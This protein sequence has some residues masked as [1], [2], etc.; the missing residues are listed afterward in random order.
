M[1]NNGPRTCPAPTVHLTIRISEQALELLARLPRQF[2]IYPVALARLAATPQGVATGE[3]HDEAVGREHEVVHERQEHATVDVAE[4]GSEAHPRVVKGTRSRRQQQADERER[5]AETTEDDENVRTPAVEIPRGDEH[6][7]A[8]DNERRLARLRVGRARA[9]RVR[10]AAA[11]LN[12]VEPPPAKTGLRRKRSRPA[13]TSREGS[14]RWR[15][16]PSRF[17]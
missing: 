16:S 8:A 4:R 13:P 12:Q 15:G 2:A 11:R 14:R 10:D 9:V 3:P 17:A 6:E 5:H 7:H 1:K